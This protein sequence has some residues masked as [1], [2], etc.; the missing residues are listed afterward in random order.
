MLR[1]VTDNLLISLRS[2]GGGGVNFRL[3]GLAFVAFPF[4]RGFLKLAKQPTPL[5]VVFFVFVVSL[6][7]LHMLQALAF[8]GTGL[9]VSRL[10]IV[11]FV[12]RLSKY[13]SILFTWLKVKQLMTDILN[14]EELSA[15]LPNHLI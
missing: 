3:S 6:V 9:T 14:N 12:A 10:F 5:F 11:L 8:F 2:R 4:R 7:M 15:S 1:N 13:N